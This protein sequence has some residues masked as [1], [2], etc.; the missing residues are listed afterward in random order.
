MS[1]NSIEKS[2]SYHKQS[3]TTYILA[4][5]KYHGKHTV[6]M[7]YLLDKDLDLKKQPPPK[8]LFLKD[9]ST[10]DAFA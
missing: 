10:L 1:V 9:Y 3:L 6:F 4:S 5:Y 8:P 7:K 2:S